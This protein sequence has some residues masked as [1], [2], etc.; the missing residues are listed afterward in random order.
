M[1]V[2]LH[3][4]LGI[5]TM[6][7]CLGRKV[8]AHLRVEPET[9]DSEASPP[10]D[11]ATAVAQLVGGD[12]LVRRPDPRPE[13]WWSSVPE[14]APIRAWQQVMQGGPTS[15][16]ALDTLE[17]THAASI[18]VPLARGARLAELEAI[19]PTTEPDEQG[20]RSLVVWLGS[21][22]VKPVPGRSD[23]RPP[24]GWL[25]TDRSTQRQALLDLMERSVLSGWLAD[26][27]LPLQPIARAMAPA[28][29]DRLRATP[30]GAL[31]DARARDAHAPDQADAAQ[32]ALNMATRLALVQAAADGIR[33]QRTAQTL[34]QELATQRGLD[35]G[36]DP[37]PGLLEDARL[38]FTADGGRPS[39]AGQAMV[40]LAAQ[41]ID[42]SCVHSPCTGVDRIA[43]LH[44]AAMQSPEVAPAAWAW[45]TI[46]V[47]TAVDRLQVSIEDALPTTVF[48]LIADLIVGEV[49]GRVPLSLLL[50]RSTGPEAAL[51]ITRGLGATDGTQPQDALQ[52][53]Q[54]LLH[55]V[56]SER[57]PELPAAWQPPI[58]RI[59]P[60]RSPPE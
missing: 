39:S 3:L 12:P 52:A 1:R 55:S 22:T 57:P 27:D 59:C 15:V 43:T 19:L 35:A 29:F 16:A 7:G 51:A 60:P 42:G 33:G 41:R 6:A 49:G 54:A 32:A 4:S 11:L 18:A 10:A 28:A 9:V 47:K 8:P 20:D 31:I 23:V 14:S 17:T 40:A 48:P 2:R 30:E 53:L 13:D 24:L 46:A 21:F 37:L 44:L 26:P 58:E 50:Q 45:R 38:G 5:A 25:G 56:C 34:S 36:A